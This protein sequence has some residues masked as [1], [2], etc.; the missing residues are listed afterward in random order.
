MGAAGGGQVL[1]CEHVRGVHRV[2][3]QMKGQQE[4]EAARRAEEERLINMLHAEE[5][6]QRATAAAEAAARKQA[7]LRAQMLAANQEQQRIKVGRPW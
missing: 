7:H 5:A 3:E 1:L 6:F 4:A 2:Y